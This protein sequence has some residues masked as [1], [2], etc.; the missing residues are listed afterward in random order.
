ML[1]ARSRMGE[2]PRFDSV[3][4]SAAKIIESAT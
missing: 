1:G 3:V 2:P 4:R